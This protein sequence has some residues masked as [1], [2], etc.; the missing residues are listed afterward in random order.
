MSGY[1]SYGGQYRDNKSTFEAEMD[2][3]PEAEFPPAE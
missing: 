3:E 2:Y 1:P